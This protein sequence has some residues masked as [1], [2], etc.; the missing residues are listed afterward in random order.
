MRIVR[1]AAAQLGPIQRADSRADVLPRLLALLQ[2]AKRERCD[3]VVFPE[4]AL[5]TFFPRWYVEER[6]DAD[7]W[8]EHE[9]PSAETVSYTHLTLPTILLV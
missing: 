2:Q 1:T 4:L 7:H 9:M 8:F 5:T 6:S 3:F